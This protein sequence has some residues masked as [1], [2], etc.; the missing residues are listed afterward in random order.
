MDVS[1]V[2]EFW[3]IAILLALTPGADWAFAIAAGVRGRWV[4]PSVAGLLVG[5]AL[6]VTVVAIGVGALVA[7]YPIALSALTIAGAGYL[8]WL[9]ATALTQPAGT[10]AVAAVT[11][12]GSGSATAHFA[13]GVGVSSI[14]PK[15]LL[16]L[17]ALL[18]QF[19]S[20]HG[21]PSSLQMLAL[22]AIHVANCALV[23]FTI[24][25]FARRVLRSRPRATAVI[26]RGA[27]TVMLLIGLSVV[28]EQALHLS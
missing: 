24:A 20:P 23:Y 10:A 21:W 17:L 15:G 8:I 13:R 14:N 11:P 9:G 4:V 28:A 5:Y 1:H 26:T 18:P 19:V 27:G 2:V 6:V 3:L 25:F 7:Q 12:A 22:G 16:L